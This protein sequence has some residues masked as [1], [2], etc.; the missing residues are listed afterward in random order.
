MLK[1]IVS[2]LILMFVT[3]KQING[4][5]ASLFQA[6]TTKDGLPSNYVFDM[7]E[8]ENGYLWI[9][10]DRGLARYDG[11]Q[12]QVFT[13][14]NGLPGNY[15]NMVKCTGKDG[16]WI[17]ISTKGIY[18]YRISS[19]QTT[20]I[21]NNNLQHYLFLNKKKDL[22]F[23]GQQDFPDSISGSYVS[24]DNPGE[25]KT[26]FKLSG[27]NFA[28]STDFE[29]K[30]LTLYPTGNPTQNSYKRLSLF[31]NWI[32]DTS[33]C[34]IK[35]VDFLEKI[36]DS[37]VCS[38]SS[39]F[40]LN[41]GKVKE[42]QL[43]QTKN[44]Y[45]SVFR[46]QNG[47]WAW[48]IK[49]GLTYV[50]DNGNT[51]CF[52]EKEGLNNL[53]INSALQARNGNMLFSTMGG[54][55][56]YKLPAGTA[57]L[58]TNDK[59]VRGLAQKGNLIMATVDNHLLTFDINRPETVSSY[60]LNDKGI[61]NINVLDNDIFISSIYGF[62]V[63]TIQ[64]NRLVK[65][66]EQKIGAGISS[67]IRVN[68]M[69]HAGSYGSHVWK[70]DPV[71][72]GRK[73][74]LNTPWVS[75]RLKPL[76]GGYVTYN[77]EDGLQLIYPGKKIILTV[78]EGL[79]SNAVFNV[80]EYK[81]TIWISTAKGLAAFTNGRIVKTFTA[82]NGI[83]GGKCKYFFIDNKGKHWLITDKYLHSS[84]GEHFTA[85]SSASL[86]EGN[87]DELVEFIYDSINNNIVT[88]SLK[89][90]QVSRL[91]NIVRRSLPLEPSL[92]LVKYDGYI[93]PNNSEFELPASYNNLSFSFKPINSNPFVST[94]LYYKLTGLDTNFT[95]L[96][97]SLTINFYKLRSGNYQLVAKTIDEN[98]IES[99]EKILISF[100]VQSPFWQ[101][102]W[103]YVLSGM[104][105]AVGFISLYAYIQKRKMRQLEN[106]RKLDDVLHTE[107]ERISK[108]L[109]DHLGTSLVIML[110]Q[111]DGA[112]TKLLQKKSAEALS[113]IQEL[114]DE[115]RAAVNILRE[116]V[117][118]VQESSHSLQDFI[119]RLKTFLQ[120]LYTASSITWEI[121]A[122]ESS[123]LLSPNQ[124]LQLFRM[125]QEISQN[126]CKHSSATTTLYTFTENKR[127]LNI[128]ISDNGKGF[129][130]SA[131]YPG[132]GLQ[133][134]KNRTT[135]LKGKLEI[136]STDE[137]GTTINITIPL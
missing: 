6:L 27:N 55:I 26:A 98:G 114:G 39:L 105:I 84:N 47:Y 46:Y 44:R 129:D 123:I 97:D 8:D 119:L 88:G 81:D 103:F 68:G 101:K 36:N 5:N 75:E 40:F 115:T 110:A 62:S 92:N 11:F 45:L 58:G 136:D 53:L 135:E 41:N 133:N 137:K 29:N 57:R 99:E 32:A 126:I 10:T 94:Q 14:E 12:W 111:A 90:I 56:N 100:H 23:Y 93:I 37:V 7:S 17:G 102:G 82:E 65:K 52:T 61:Q 72:K 3:C 120:R 2:Y 85:L 70:Y 19:G 21:V 54:G 95:E 74:D 73:E 24:A 22:F 106:Q 20:F 132:N 34:T 38:T 16:I 118:A 13:T 28:V 77:Y 79:P 31:N 49:D 96:K 127:Q 124:T 35:G 117:W 121:N 125:L 59:P 80:Y 69:Y 63:Y 107:R 66:D 89:K 15:I 1:G 116:T 4:Q 48:N 112:E 60:P 9:G 131:A 78:K 67:V 130:T 30:K 86:T 104:L 108:D 51:T 18:H 122:P 113:K 76:A 109:H 134:L 42:I 33:N 71:T 64:G 25:I 43:Y 87:N 91:D 50:N 128:C 83:K